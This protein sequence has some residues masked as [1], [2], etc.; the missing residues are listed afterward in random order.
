MLYIN[1][2][3]MVSHLRRRESI[4]VLCPPIFARIDLKVS[5]GGYVKNY[6]QNQLFTIMYECEPSFNV[7]IGARVDRAPAVLNTVLFS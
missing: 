5:D 2:W 1:L 4:E 6:G 3:G 7:N